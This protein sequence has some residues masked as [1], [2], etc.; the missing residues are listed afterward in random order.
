MKKQLANILEMCQSISQA[1]DEDKIKE[2]LSGQ[3]DQI[4]KR[5]PISRKK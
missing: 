3:K 1:I 2:N 4:R 5:N